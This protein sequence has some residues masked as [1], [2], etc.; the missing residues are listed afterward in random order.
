VAPSPHQRQAAS[1]V[2]D[3]EQTQVD[4]EKKAK[5]GKKAH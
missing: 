5:K 3:S 2:T 1:V 4:A